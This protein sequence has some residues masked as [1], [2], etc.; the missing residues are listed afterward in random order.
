[1]FCFD[2]NINDL[3]VDGDGRKIY[4]GGDP[5]FIVTGIAFRFV[6]NLNPFK[7]FN[8]DSIPFRSVDVLSIFTTDL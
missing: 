4:S 7:L 8:S 6:R 5:D 1:M 2:Q 3:A